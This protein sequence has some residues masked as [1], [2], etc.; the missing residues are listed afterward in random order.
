MKNLLFEC[1]LFEKSFIFS[2][3]KKR[4]GKKP[5]WKRPSREKIGGESTGQL[6]K[7]PPNESPQKSQQ[8]GTEGLKESP[9]L[10][11]Y[12]VEFNNIPILTMKV[13]LIKTT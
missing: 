13:K 5:A 2:M 10:C 3:G 6:I 1:L 8:S 9:Q 4:E 11:P 12:H 7:A